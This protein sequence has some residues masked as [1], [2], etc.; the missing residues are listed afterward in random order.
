M[1]AYLSLFE[2]DKGMKFNGIEFIERK[3]DKLGHTREELQ[4]FINAVMD[5]NVPDYQISAWLMAA[6]LNGLD[7]NELM[8]FTHALAHSGETLNY[9]AGE[10]VIDKH[11]TGGVGDK[12]TLV[13]IPLVAAC[14]A[15]ISKL[16]GPGLGY[17]GGTIDKLES[18]PGMNMHLSEVEF[19]DQVNKI[20]CAISGHS[21][22][23]APAEGK[24]YR[25]RDVTGTVPSIPL[26]T[27]SIVSKKLAGGAYGYLFDVKC[28]SGAFMNDLEKAG[29]LARKLVDISKKLGKLC[30]SVITD[31][32]QPLGEWVGN[33]A[34]VYEAVEVLS[35]GGPSDTREL[36]LTLASHM[37]NM[38]GRARTPEEGATLSAKALDDGSALKKFGELVSAQ[39][40]DTDVIREPEKVLPRASST[41]EIKSDRDGYLSKLDALLIGEGL[42]A[43]GG[44]RLT[45]EDTIDPSVA[46]QMLCKTGDRVCKG[47]VVLRIYY[48]REKQLQESL[49]YIEKS[50]KVSDSSEKR[51]LIID[52]VY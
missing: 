24:F 28:G 10:M 46:V 38:S 29:Q 47:D 26:I 25:L 37:L 32:E 11:S 7:D 5:E 33:S 12:T 30:V 35:G 20:G 48:N 41:Y 50:W 18:I 43:L 16:S 44:G 52:M 27:A 13:L 45:Q 39:K 19:R 9:P 34:E 21:L 49:D 1:Q 51:R 40:G 23:L 42:R 14:G 4:S 2:G 6:F 15:R 8:Y 22:K 36:C 3:R 31:M 17:T